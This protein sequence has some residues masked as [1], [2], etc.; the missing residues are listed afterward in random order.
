MTYECLQ[1]LSGAPQSELD[2]QN[3]WSA[4]L[5]SSQKAACLYSCQTMKTQRKCCLQTT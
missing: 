1:M 4:P 5:I 3:Q 2:V